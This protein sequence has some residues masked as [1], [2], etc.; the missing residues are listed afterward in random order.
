M[1]GRDEEK[2]GYP[3][4]EG[5]LITLGYGRLG[6][7]FVIKPCAGNSCTQGFCFFIKG[8]FFGMLNQF[9]R[10]ELAFGKEGVRLL[11]QSTVAI[12]GIGG[13]GSF[14]AEALC[15]SGIGKI[16]LIDKDEIDVTNINRQIHALHETIGMPKVKAM[17]NR[18][19]KINP[20]VTVVPMQ[21]FYTDE[22]YQEVFAESIDFMIDASDTITFKIHMIK[23]CLAREIPFISSMGAANKLDPTQLKIAD[24]FE[25]RYDPLAKVIRKEL[26]KAGI[27]KGVPVVYSEESPII[28]REEIRKEIVSDEN[29]PIRKVK[30]PPASN[31]FVP[32]T[33]GLI[34]AS[35]VVRMLTKDIPIQRV[36]Q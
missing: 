35:Y 4:S 18:M 10:N 19:K 11:E 20:N 27:T 22:T 32:S 15:R 21:M 3:R 26:R 12:L 16:I 6:D 1:I 17:A 9:S 34:C 7:F 33:A 29:H 2:V 14:A 25:T 13:V 8:G 36:N 24:L 30:Q 31:A 5:R 23:E 28:T